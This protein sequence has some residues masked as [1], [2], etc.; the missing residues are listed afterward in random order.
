MAGDRTLIPYVR[1]HNER[2]QRQKL[3]DRARYKMDL[4]A[5]E[6]DRCDPGR[7][8]CCS[9]EVEDEHWHNER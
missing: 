4:P 1:A 7:C 3:S 8:A 6:A 9:K 2:Q 5:H